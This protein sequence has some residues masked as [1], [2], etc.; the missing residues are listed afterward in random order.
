MQRKACR[1]VPMTFVCH[2]S[3]RQS[4]NA[5]QRHRAALWGILVLVSALAPA[6]L[7]GATS[8]EAAHKETLHKRPITTSDVIRMARLSNPDYFNRGLS[9]D[10]VALFAPDAKHFAIVIRRG[11]AGTDRNDFSLFVFEAARLL[12]EAKPI[13]TFSSSSNRDG[14][15]GLIW[16]ADNETLA[17]IGETPNIEAQVYTINIHTARLTARTQQASSVTAFDITADGHSILYL[18]ERPRGESCSGEE[19]N[20]RV[21]EEGSLLEA[22]EDEC[23]KTEERQ[24]FFQKGEQRPVR[25]A[26]EDGM[27]DES[28]L[29]LAPDGCHAVLGTYAREYPRNWNRYQGSYLRRLMANKWKFKEVAFFTLKRYQLLDTGTFSVVPILNTPITTFKE[30]VWSEDGNSVFLRNVFLPLEGGDQVPSEE[31]ERKTF[32]VQIRLIDLNWK[33]VSE[34][35]WPERQRPDAEVSVELEEGINKP[36]RI[37]ARARKNS[38]KTL[39]LDL[40]PQFAELE[41]GRVELMEWSVEGIP[42]VGGLYLPPNYIRGKRYPL[43]IQTH[44]FEPSRFSMDGRNE[45]SSG[46]AARPLAAAGIL[47]L[48]AFHYR[49]ADDSART[50][51]NRA[52]GAT[53]EQSHKKF[54]ALAYEAAILHLERMGLIDS[55]RVGI[56]GFS[57]SV[58]FVGYALSHSSRRYAA[59][60]LTDGIDCGYFGYL[61]FPSAAWDFDNLNGGLSPFSIG[62][63]PRWLEE[64]PPFN[65]D[66]VR[67]PVRLVALGR[68]SILE[69]WEWY[70]GLNLQKKAVDFVEIPEAVHQLQR[71]QDRRTAQ[72]GLVDWFRFWL[73]GMEDGDPRK[74]DQYRRW[75]ALRTAREEARDGD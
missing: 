36:P 7:P 55:G 9:I 29:E 34:Q 26:V 10:H 74:A 35:E 50:S 4:R 64:A 25:V 52:L 61:S 33:I 38:E 49:N 46:F 19:G 3:P 27:V 58:C 51:Q 75:R 44:G 69:E 63:L 5:A 45:W 70:V 47:V 66:K 37:Y 72:D 22:L 15:H 14:I 60:V 57:R 1:C 48:Q 62:G 41:F 24:L 71:V 16:L 68:N 32:D 40:N 20:E 12:P 43:V 28:L 11:D 31:R 59:A 54:E 21:V 67:T 8:E 53:V 17:F 18:A 13:L 65:L 42:V 39:L 56:S 23:A 73:T 6:M 2:C 30:A